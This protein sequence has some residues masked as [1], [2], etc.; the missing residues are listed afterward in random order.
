MGDVCEPILQWYYKTIQQ[1]LTEYWRRRGGR[2]GCSQRRWCRRWCACPAGREA[3]G[4]KQ[5]RRSVKRSTPTAK[6]VS[7]LCTSA[8]DEPRDTESENKQNAHE[9]HAQ[10]VTPCSPGSQH[11]SSTAAENR[12][13]SN[14]TGIH[15]KAQ[16]AS[17]APSCTAVGN[18]T[19]T[20]GTAPESCVSADPNPNPMT[21]TK[22]HHSNVRLT[23]Q[24]GYVHLAHNSLRQC[25]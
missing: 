13:V 18:N 17:S 23:M 21:T 7:R 22:A 24:P 10:T 19:K 3:I 8:H 25:M 12:V 15:G 6:N 16:Q 2:G 9:W 14:G 1:P 5:G 4:K 11:S 20:L